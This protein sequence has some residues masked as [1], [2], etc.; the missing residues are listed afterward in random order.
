MKIPSI[1]SIRHFIVSWDA[2]K[3]IVSPAREVIPNYVYEI[4]NPEKPCESVYKSF[5]NPTV[6]SV[7]MRAW[8]DSNVD[9]NVAMKSL[10]SALK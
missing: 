7:A 5:S 9:R 10:A 4:M 1:R 2:G 8:S 6:P 3:L